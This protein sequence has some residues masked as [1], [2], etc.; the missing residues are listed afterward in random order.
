MKRVQGENDEN[1]SGEVMGR[2]LKMSESWSGER[3]G[4]CELRPNNVS[5][6]CHVILTNTR[7]RAENSQHT[8]TLLFSTQFC[9]VDPLML[10]K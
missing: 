8:D 5:Q 3:T 6:V 10:L 7:R 4:D 9:L 1:G 2:W